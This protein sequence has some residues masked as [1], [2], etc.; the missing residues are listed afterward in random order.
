MRLNASMKLVVLL[1]IRWMFL[2]MANFG[3]LKYKRVTITL[4]KSHFLLIL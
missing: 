2:V 4:V 3:I 1:L